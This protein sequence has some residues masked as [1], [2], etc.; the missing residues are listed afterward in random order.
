MRPVDVAVALHGR[1][2]FMQ[3]H[4]VTDFMQGHA[5]ECV[6]LH[7]IGRCRL[8]GRGGA[9]RAVAV[10]GDGGATAAGLE[11]VDNVR[12]T[13]TQRKGEV[14][15]VQRLIH[16]VQLGPSGGCMRSFELLR[17]GHLRFQRTQYRSR[18]GLCAFQLGNLFLDKSQRSASVTHIAFR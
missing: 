9:N 15:A 17:L 12:R 7:G 13:A 18:L 11:A 16:G 4:A 3:G 8:Y 10:V 1:Y 5:V 2:P 6:R 14:E